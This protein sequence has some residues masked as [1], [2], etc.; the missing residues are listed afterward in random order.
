MKWLA[1]KSMIKN[2]QI[3]EQ[4]LLKENAQLKKKIEQLEKENK[5]LQTN[6]T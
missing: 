4:K 3:I 6:N 2:L 5:K 1:R